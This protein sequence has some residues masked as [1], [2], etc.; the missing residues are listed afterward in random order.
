MDHFDHYR[1]DFKVVCCYRRPYNWCLITLHIRTHKISHGSLTILRILKNV[2]PRWVIPFRVDTIPWDESVRAVE[3]ARLL[4]IMSQHESRIISFDFLITKLHSNV[5]QIN[6]NFE[7]SP[8]ESTKHIN[9]IKALQ[10][11]KTNK[12]SIQLN[13]MQMQIN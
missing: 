13:I 8:K 2:L 5:L 1:F 10:K 9:N 6:F 12:N 7:I 11:H 4:A 3:S